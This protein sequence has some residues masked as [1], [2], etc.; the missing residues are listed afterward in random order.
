M[1]L[2]EGKNKVFK[3]LKKGIYKK[4]NPLLSKRFFNQ[5]SIKFN[6]GFSSCSY[7]LGYY[8]IFALSGYGIDFKK[9]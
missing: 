9:V 5:G 7:L 6:Q 4:I 8:A 2:K 3:L 1:I